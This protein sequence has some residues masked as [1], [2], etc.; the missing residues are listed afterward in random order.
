M[1]YIYTQQPHIQAYNIAEFSF[2]TSMVSNAHD[3]NDKF[4]YVC[5]TAP[6]ALSE[7]DVEFLRDLVSNVSMYIGAQ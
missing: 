1:T 7:V 6:Q 2:I 4:F 5:K 3:F